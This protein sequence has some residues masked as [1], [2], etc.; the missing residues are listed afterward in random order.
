MSGYV[1]LKHGFSG[2]NYLAH[3]G[4][5]GM[6]WGV[7]RFQ[8]KDGSLT[9]AGRERYSDNT[10]KSDKDL[11]SS[12]D[13]IKNGKSTPDDWN[14]CAK[15]L[16]SINSDPKVSS[17]LEDSKKQSIKLEEIYRDWIQTGI[18]GGM[19]QITEAWHKHVSTNPKLSEMENRIFDNQKPYAE[20]VGASVLSKT[21]NQ[22]ISEF[23]ST[24]A[25]EHYFDY[26][27]D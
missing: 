21:N 13:R 18:S 25:R 20:A 16:N 10:N 14:S 12:I 6:K 27:Y 9:K 8:N 19:D 11:K 15:A 26:V 7:R 5:L 24:F 3:H 1:Y 22:Q 2:A 4:I 23:M 17:I